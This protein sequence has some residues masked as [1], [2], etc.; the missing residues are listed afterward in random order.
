MRKSISFLKYPGP[1]YLNS[2]KIQSMKKSYFLIFS[3]AVSI[4][5]FTQIDFKK[6]Q[7]EYISRK[8]F[9]DKMQAYPAVPYDSL[10]VVNEEGISISF[11]WLPHE[12]NKGT[13]LL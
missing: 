10:K 8:P 1:G 7:Q 6:L 4:Q 3:L 9:L 12:K 13:A 11:W 5:S 2:K